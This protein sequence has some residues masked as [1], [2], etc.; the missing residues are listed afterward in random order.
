MAFFLRERLQP[1]AF[2]LLPA[3]NRSC[4][5]IAPPMVD[6]GGRRLLH[7]RPGVRG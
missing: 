1:R 2:P 6:R 7:H 3:S 5:I 4:L